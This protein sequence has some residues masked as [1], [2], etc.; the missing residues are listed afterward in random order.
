[1]L[2]SS[3]PPCVHIVDD[4]AEVRDAVALLLRSVGLASLQY[5]SAAQFL[6][7]YRRGAPGCLL[8]DVRLPGLNGLDL[9]ERLA[10]AGIQLPVIVMSGHGDIPMAV[11]AMRAGALDFIEKP[12]H[13]QA[14]LDR[15]HQAIELSG[16][17]HADAGEHQR[18]AERYARLSE[19]EKQVLQAIVEGRPNKLIADDL[20]LSIRTVETHRAHLI[21]KMEAR[22]LSQLVRMA[23]Q[24]LPP[25]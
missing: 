2:P 17:A 5:G 10:A 4:E 18:I 14:L 8:L 16:R 12:F 7:E 24:V 6:A 19:R 25:R 22:S 3:L 9:Q 13:D 23:V 15:V 20:G 1:M 11:R 21:E